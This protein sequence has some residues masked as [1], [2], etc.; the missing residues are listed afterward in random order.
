M[1]TQ[2]PRGTK[3]I[4]GRP[5]AA[6]QRMEETLRKTCADFGMSEI[7]TPVFEHTELFLRGVGENTDIAQK[8]MY[9]FLDKGDRSL[10]LRPEITA[11]VARAFVEHKLYAETLP[12][13]FYYIGPN[14]RY[15]KP[16]AGRWR[17]FHQF[18]AEIFGSFHPAAEAEMISL[19]RET[20]LRLR[21]QGYELHLNSLGGPVCRGAYNE[22]LKAFLA[23]RLPELCP[24][25]QTRFQ[26]NPLRVL[27]CKEKKCQALLA[28]APTPL[29]FLGAECQAHFEELQEILTAMDISFMVD[30]KVVRGLDYYT[31]TVFEFIDTETELTLCGGGRYDGLIEECG[32]PRTGAAGFGMG[33][34][35]ILLA[36]ERRK[37]TMEERPLTRVYIGAIGKA[38]FLKA[39]EIT[40]ALRREGVAA[41]T[42]TLGRYGRNAVK[43][44]MKYADKMGVPYSLILG[45]NELES[46]R[47]ILKNMETGEQKEIALQA[48]KDF[49]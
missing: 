47:V 28:D 30:P 41:E 8:E 37:D 43:A 22:R 20:L 27:D 32:G 31:R 46:G 4:Y 36:L 21:L 49:I 26:K 34:E 7:R 5:M 13:K 10:T 19:A 18:G 6:W 11:G 25:C 33:L 39:Q 24:A 35:R 23:E 42:D 15:E 16:A 9:T 29:A 14:F 44:Q 48:L 3:D 17:Q 1:L 40:L 2:T 12:I 38:G 45:D